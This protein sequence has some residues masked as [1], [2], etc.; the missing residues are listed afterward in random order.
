M[1]RLESDVCVVGAGYAGLTA[2]RRLT[3]GAKSVTVL[4]ARDRVGGRVFTTRTTDG[5][6]IDIGGTWL[7]VGQ[8]AA[9]DLAK[10]LSVTT[11][12][13]WVKGDSVIFIKGQA[14]RYK[15]LLPK[16]GPVALAA[17]GLGMARLDAMAKKVPLD[18]PWSAPKAAKWD[19]LSAGAWV[20]AHVP[21]GAG[22]DLLL[23]T[24]GG[25]FTSDPSEVSLLH[26][27]YLIRSANGLNALLSVEGGYEEDMLNG[28]AGAMAD[29]MAADL[30]DALQLGTPVR[31]VTQDDRAI[32]V[33]GDGV[34]VRA[35][36]VIIAIPPALAA[37]IHYAPGLPTD[38]K[39]LL[40]RAPA[41]AAIKT[42]AVYDEPFWRSDGLSGETVGIDSPV[43]ITLDSCAEDAAVGI[44]SGYVFGPHARKLGA[45]PEAERHNVVIEEFARRLGPKARSPRHV[46]QQ[47]WLAE[48]WTRGGMI[49]R[50]AP[51]VLTQ[52][53]YTL[54]QPAGR[55]H[56]AGTETATTC[57]GTI[58]GAVRSGERAAAEVLAAI[59]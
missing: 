55:I 24:V 7:G 27:L 28:G 43:S 59:A 1:K 14:R 42:V 35:Q 39:L 11:Y 22:R 23:A 57:H 25:L 45:L 46:V 44:M 12:K 16:I 33:E 49:A 6:L 2:A 36:R 53:G 5:T 17:I 20:T 4:E 34:A 50:F 19:R 29:H 47:D 3:Q 21:R 38:K 18:A 40:A 13:T 9:H 52:F 54:R 31:A 51:G 26:L 10:E 58:D 48:E 56:W 41:G 32:E 8:D 15:G 30:G 37:D